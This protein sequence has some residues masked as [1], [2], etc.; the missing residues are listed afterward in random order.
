M[1]IGVDE[2]DGITTMQEANLKRYCGKP[3]N[4][5]ECEERRG[6]FGGREKKL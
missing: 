4:N 6:W 3:G 1:E 2:N 5:D